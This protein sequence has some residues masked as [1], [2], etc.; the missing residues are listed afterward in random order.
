MR[1]IISVFFVLLFG[2]GTWFVYSSAKD[3]VVQTF[4]SEPITTGFIGISIIL[5]VLFFVKFKPYQF[6]R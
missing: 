4:G 1:E 3:W 5:F 2:L 6:I